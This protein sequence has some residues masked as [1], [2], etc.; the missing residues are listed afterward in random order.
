MAKEQTPMHRSI[1]TPD[2]SVQPTRAFEQMGESAAQLQTTLANKAQE[3]AVDESTR[4][5]IRD[6][7]EGRTPKD[8][9]FPFTQATKAYNTAVERTEKGRLA[10]AAN[11]QINEA[12]I[13]FSN[14]ATFNHETPAQFKAHVNGI[15]E[16][17]L[18]NARDGYREELRQ[19]LAEQAD[20]ASFR[21][22]EHAITYDNKVQENNFNFDIKNLAEEAR[23]AVISGESPEH[24]YEEMNKKVDDYAAMNA[25]IASQVPMIKKQL[26]EEREVN[27]LFS[28]YAKAHEE[29]KEAE[30]LNDLASNKQNLP[31]NVWSK[32][33]S[34]LYNLTAQEKR[35]K[36]DIQGEE[37]QR[38]I[39]AILDGQIQTP[40]DFDRLPNL[41]TTQ[42]LQLQA[43]WKQN[44]QRQIRHTN[45]L[46]EAQ[47]QILRGTPAMIS[48]KTTDELLEN[49][50]LEFEQ[51]TGR[52][53]TLTDMTESLTGQNDLPL[54]GIPSTPLGRDVPK[55]NAQ[56][57]S[58]LSSKNPELFMEAAENF[59]RVVNING[60]KSSI[61]I[62]G[63]ELT[64]ATLFNQL[65]IGSTDPLVLAQEVHDTVYN[66]PETEFNLRSEQ[67]HRQYE[68]NPRTGKPALAT[69]FKDLFGVEPDAFNNAAAFDYYRAQFKLHY[70]ASNSEEAAAEATAYD[71]RAAGESKYFKKGFVSPASV[72]E[73]ELNITQ[74]GYAFP[75]Q[76]AFNMQ[77]V[78]N[79]NGI[80][81][82]RGVAN[83]PK[84]E[85]RNERERINFEDYTPEDRVF[86]N[87]AATQADKAGRATGP[88]DKPIIKITDT[89]QG[90]PRTWES[91]VYLVPIPESRLGERV[92]Y[93]LGYDDPIGVQHLIPDITAPGGHALFSPHGLDVW[94]PEVFDSRRQHDLNEM[95]TKML[96]A[97][98][99]AELKSIKGFTELRGLPFLE[100]IDLKAK[101]MRD[102]E[103]FKDAFRK[104]QGEDKQS[105]MDILHQRIQRPETPAQQLATN[106]QQ[107]EEAVTA[108]NTG[109][110]ADTGRPEGEQ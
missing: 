83:L 100:S 20:K 96:R 78:I 32:G 106:L 42:K 56:Y 110:A 79:Q 8:L 46:L 23:T 92:Q 77:R 48:G 81:R 40:E 80:D 72:P 24:F 36:N 3:L 91:E 22:L 97:E 34:E 54:S 38:G 99:E 51:V 94:A 69:K 19:H 98:G 25:A 27:N 6:V 70:L 28:G 55:I 41:T 109:I 101:Q 107:Q 59:N 89:F 2:I 50:R 30:F 90:R 16:G 87:I 18:E 65:N 95:A 15:I 108:N 33:V 57:K 5:G 76:I 62:G 61:N 35:L 60:D 21:M 26:Q 43:K 17:T 66:V 58:Q 75:N 103:R 44:T 13:N 4:E 52:R 31:F 102:P 67:F 64:A 47:Q 85:W 29:G 10:H 73:K 63:R 71:M 49:K 86:K 84:L 45:G 39:N 88:T 9:A 68:V 14:P 37:Y 11:K 12:L 82:N 74:I 1:L 93:A 53:M 7:E 104:M 105:I